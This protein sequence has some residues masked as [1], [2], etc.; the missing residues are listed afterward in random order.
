LNQVPI[1]HICDGRYDCAAIGPY[2]N[3]EK[4]CYVFAV[5]NATLFFVTVVCFVV[6][7]LP[8]SVMLVHA[9]QWA[10]LGGKLNL[11]S[12]FDGGDEDVPDIG[13]AE[14]G[15]EKKENEKKPPC[16]VS[17]LPSSE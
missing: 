2:D 8:F 12:G 13:D 16:D 11:F 6:F 10:C 5:N 9:E 3:D 17:G 7:L 1:S 4:G 15:P 14:H